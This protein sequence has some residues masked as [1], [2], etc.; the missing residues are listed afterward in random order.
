MTNMWFMESCR[1]A[2]KKEGLDLLEGHSF[3]IG[4]TTH[5]L[6][7]GVDPWVVMVIGRWLLNTFL[8]YLR[9]VEEVLPN[10]I[11]EAYDAVKCLPPACHGLYKIW[12]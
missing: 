3:R 7:S 10:F 2:W 12:P 1:G 6:M 11:S 9:K 4:G 8:M 5:H